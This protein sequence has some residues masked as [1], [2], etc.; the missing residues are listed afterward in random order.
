MRKLEVINHLGKEIYFLDFSGM[1]DKAEIETLIT[2]GKRIIRSKS[3]KSVFSLTNIEE[4]HFNNEIKDL[5]TE[6]IKGNKTFIKASAVLGVTGIRQIVF[7][8][9]M[10]ITGREIRLFD[11]ADVAKRWLVAHP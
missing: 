5:F 1:K 6:F 10:K 2:E 11:S 7:N 8:G 4:M 9:V 3:P